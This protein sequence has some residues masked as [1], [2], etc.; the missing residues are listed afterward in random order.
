MNIQR[1]LLIGAVLLGTAVPAAAQI[2]FQV[3]F[4][5]HHHGRSFRVSLGSGPRHHHRAYH[6]HHFRYVDRLVRVWVPGCER[7][8]YVPARYG[9][10]LDVCGRRVRYCIAQAHYR[11]IQEP[12][13]WEYRRERV[14][15]RH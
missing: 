10:R 14:R 3:S 7:R 1:L 11:L 4:G 8:I 5:G 12:G 13:R 15:V 2:G 9:Y 6:R